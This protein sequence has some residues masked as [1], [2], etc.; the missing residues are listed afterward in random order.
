[1]SNTQ[2]SFIGR[3]DRKEES[4]ILNQ[5]Q[6]RAFVERLMGNRGRPIV[7][8]LYGLKRVR[9]V[10]VPPRTTDGSCVVMPRN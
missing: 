9:N 10:Y 8:K 1:M 2:L 4:M 6:E 7:Q 3:L 5:Q